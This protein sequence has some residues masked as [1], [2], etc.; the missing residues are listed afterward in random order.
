MK[1]KADKS[2][3]TRKQLS[4]ITNKTTDENEACTKAIRK[5]YQVF[6]EAFPGSTHSKE[7]GIQ[8]SLVEELEEVMLKRRLTAQIANWPLSQ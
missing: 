4:N 2:K 1:S 5:I 8:V 3:E 6:M 7:R